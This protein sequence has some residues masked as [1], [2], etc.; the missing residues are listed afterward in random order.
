MLRKDKDAGGG[1]EQGWRKVYDA[2]G[3][4]EKVLEVGI[5]C[6]R[7]RGVVL[8]KLYDAGGGEEHGWRKVYD[9][10]GSWGRSIWG[11]DDSGGRQGPGIGEG[12]MLIKGN[13]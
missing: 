4:G 9:A 13:K 12:K 8:R 1:G 7:G 2:G 10:G 3:E 11:R 6:W 5:Q